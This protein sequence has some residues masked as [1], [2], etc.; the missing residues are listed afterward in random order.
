MKCVKKFP[1][2]FAIGHRVTAG[3]FDGPVEITEK[4]DGC[5]TPNT[6]ILKT[7][8]EY[9][10]AGELCV[11]D[12]LLAF[13]SFLNNPKF[14]KTKVTHTCLLKKPCYKIVTSRGTIH[15]SVDHPWL[16]RDSKR[17]INGLSK[18]WMES[19]D[20][21]IGDK[22]VYLNS[23]ETEESWE[24]GYLA[25][26]FDGEGTI[27]K[28]GKTRRVAF[29]QK[30]GIELDYV[31]QLLIERGYSVSKKV[32]QREN[33]KWK[34]SG[35]ISINGGWPEMLRFLGSIR[36]QRLLADSKKLW[37]NAAMNGVSD[38]EILS[39]EYA[40]RRTVVGLSTDSETYIAEGFL[41]HNSQFGF[42]KI[43]GYLSMRSKNKEI[44]SDSTQGLFDA[45]YKQIK[46]IEHLIPDN[47]SFWAEY[48]SKP[49]H[50]VLKYNRIP[51]NHLMLFGM[52]MHSEP[53]WTYS[54]DELCWWANEFEF[55]IA[56]LIY[57]GKIENPKR[58]LDFL[59]RESYLGGPKIEGVVAKNW[60]KSIMIGDQYIWPVSGKYVAE[61]F[62]EKMGQRTKHFSSG[63]KWE[64]YKQSF[65]TEARWR[66][67]IQH[68]R[69]E[70][71]LL[72]EPKDIG[73]LLKEI[74][75]DLIAE[76]KEEIMEFLWK[77]YG[78]EVCRVATAGFPE[79]YKDWLLKSAFEEE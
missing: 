50:N 63:G 44:F 29:Y 15:A 35:I 42:G 65:R 40:G 78:K 47:T 45:A 11:G 23:W 19:K 61:K 56:H 67:A 51:T 31:E 68:L 24:A 72:C 79:F 9:I 26:Q 3:L 21:S 6:R 10:R 4:V 58:L 57:V 60:A 33:P 59:H 76:H 66:K 34:P 73:P 69:E 13:D 39:I 20:L 52:D 55:D 32:R 8:L 7:N 16:I 18:I 22:I 25:G 74:N 54:Y 43:D 36:P 28:S 27:L 71:R 1:K 17:K 53:D 2:I 62:K 49:K 37:E 41:S 38:A 46:R 77:S 12:E 70:G 75:Q 30:K 48:L 64:D 14:K 5:V